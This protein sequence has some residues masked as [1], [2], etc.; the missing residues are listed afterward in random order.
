MALCL[1][2]AFYPR[3]IPLRVLWMLIAILGQFVALG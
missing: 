1:F 3:P 2:L